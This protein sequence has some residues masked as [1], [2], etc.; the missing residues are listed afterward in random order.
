MQNTVGRLVTWYNI[1]YLWYLNMNVKIKHMHTSKLGQRLVNSL[2]TQTHTEFKSSAVLCS[3]KS[4]CTVAVFLSKDHYVI[5]NKSAPSKALHPPH[6]THT[7]PPEGLISER[8]SCIAFCFRPPTAP[9]LPDESAHSSVLLVWGY[10]G[11]AIPCLMS[12]E[13]KISILALEWLGSLWE[14]L[15]CLNETNRKCIFQ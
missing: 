3:N 8:I 15:C 11:R 9:W 12:S 10:L 14:Q 1:W 4:F 7:Q 13:A 6:H 2:Q 5:I